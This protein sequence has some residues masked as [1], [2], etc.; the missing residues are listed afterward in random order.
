MASRGRC[1]V[2]TDLANTFEHRFLVLL[3][4]SLACIIVAN[5]LCAQHIKKKNSA[6]YPF[7]PLPPEADNLSFLTEGDPFYKGPSPRCERNMS[8][9]F[10]C[11]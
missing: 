3:C 4:P 2:V 11:L 5:R 8:I 1:C 9:F 7:T 10:F 6:L